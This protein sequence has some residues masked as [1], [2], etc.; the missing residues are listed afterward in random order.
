VRWLA[1]ILLAGCA[2]AAGLEIGGPDLAGPGCGSQDDCSGDLVCMPATVGALRGTCMP[3]SAMHCASCASDADCDSPTARCL[4][5]PG[6]VQAACHLD[7]SLSFLAC[8]PDYNCA[9]VLDGPITRSLCL[10]MSNLCGPAQGGACT[11]A[12]TQPCSRSG[13][14]GTCVG[15]RTCV[16]GVFG[17]CDAADPQPLATCAD[18]PPAGCTL[19]PSDAAIS[20]P[21]DCGS[22]G[23]AC[24]GVTAST[25]EAACT[26]PA[27]SQCG[28]SCRGDN[29]DVDG[30]AANGC[31]VPDPAPG[32][33]LSSTPTVFANT[34]CND[35][36]SQNT[37]T[38]RLLSDTHRHLDPTVAGFDSTA[39]SAPHYYSV[40]SSGGT[41][42][43]DDYSV[44]FTTTG[45][46]D[47]PCYEATI[48]T[49]KVINSVFISGSSSGTISGGAG[50]Y[51]DGST[52]LFKVQKTCSPASV[53][54][55]DVSF[56][57][58]YHL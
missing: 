15:K 44:T 10:P 30:D 19:V 29:W 54:A 4:Q 20:T 28:I 50:S 52:I 34:D 51:T 8:P 22:C 5:A 57:V 38:G 55:S 27:T 23:H 31:E 37:F 56:T 53:G 46:P 32:N 9:P 17:A 3:A 7:C 13:P 11:G 47:V 36:D 49:D 26:D 45:G 25:A 40:Y 43:Q 16:N 1:L 18:A 6:D 39:G 33:H 48:M 24:P 35:G 21:T 58:S 14:G 2:G 12:A 42:C 41:L